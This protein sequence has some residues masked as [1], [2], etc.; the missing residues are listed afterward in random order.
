MLSTILVSIL[1]CMMHSNPTS[2]KNLV[3]FVVDF[4]FKTCSYYA[5]LAILELAE[6]IFLSRLS[7]VVTAC[8]FGCFQFFWDRV[9]CRT[10]LELL[11]SSTE[12]S[13]RHSIILLAY[14]QHLIGMKLKLIDV[15]VESKVVDTMNIPKR[16]MG[17]VTLT[18]FNYEN[19]VLFSQMCPFIFNN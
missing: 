18:A 17:L 4:V 12:I 7:A 11:N 9:A 8:G 5:S 1:T 15:I 6:I 2:T 3:A 10:S 16:L 19:R 13:C 14:T